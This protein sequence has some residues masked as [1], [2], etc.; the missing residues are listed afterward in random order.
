MHD[1]K[2]ASDTSTH[3]GRSIWK[4]RMLPCRHPGESRDPFCPSWNS[5][6]CDQSKMDPGFGRDEGYANAQRLF[7]SGRVSVTGFPRSRE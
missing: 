6:G 4:N 7:S 3:Y 5:N 2:S 1:R